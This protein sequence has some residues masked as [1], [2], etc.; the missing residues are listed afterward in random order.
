MFSSISSQ[1]RGG[2]EHSRSSDDLPKPLKIFRFLGF[3]F[4]HGVPVLIA[5][6][7][8]CPSSFEARETTFIP[9]KPEA[10]RC[11]R[12][13]EKLE[14]FEAKR[15]PHQSQ[16]THFSENEIN[17]FLAIELSPRY[18][19][20]LKSLTLAFREDYLKATAK[21]D[22]DQ[23]GSTASTMLPKFM[24]FIFP[25]IHVLSAEGRLVTKDG[26]AHFKLERSFWDNQ[27][28]P[29]PLVEM[30]IST[31]GRKQNPPFDPLQPS[32]M[33]YGIDRVEL[34]DGYAIVFQ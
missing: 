22:M 3:T 34:H 17:S 8:T 16:S 10:Q 24:G 4:G 19:P 21:I 9:S 31:V 1:K 5:L 23:A 11:R 29:K 12:K 13:L 28:L 2:S 30:I 33:P 20:C 32:Q 14:A 26:K 6:L 27:S 25:G 18:H 7:L 15:K